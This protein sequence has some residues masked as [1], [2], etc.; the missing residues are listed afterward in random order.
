MHLPKSDNFAHAAFLDPRKHGCRRRWAVRARGGQPS[1]GR[2]AQGRRKVG[3]GEKGWEGRG[4]W[5][6]GT[7]SQRRVSGGRE[8]GTPPRAAPWARPIRAADPGVPSSPWQRDAQALAGRGGGLDLALGNRVMSR[9]KVGMAPSQRLSSSSE[10]GREA[11]AVQSPGAGSSR[12]DATREGNVQRGPK[13]TQPGGCAHPSRGK[14]TG[15]GLSAVPTRL[16]L[17]RLRQED[18]T[19]KDSLSRLA[20]P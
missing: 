13:T 6:A 5:A 2:C 9:P 12:R 1:S 20:G 14:V 11:T 19:I 4:T 8:L 3:Q 15:R 17:K 7:P 10:R 18:L 16:L